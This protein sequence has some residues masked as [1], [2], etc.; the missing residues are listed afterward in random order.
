[1]K[2]KALWINRMAEREKRLREIQLR[3]SIRESLEMSNNQYD[4]DNT[5]MGI[6]HFI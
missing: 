5:N 2:M 4:G 6:A 3:L 1:M